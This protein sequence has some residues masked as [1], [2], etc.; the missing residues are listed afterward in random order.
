MYKIIVVL[1]SLFAV[2]HSNPNRS[3]NSFYKLLTDNPLSITKVLKNYNSRPV[4]RSS[5]S[6][7]HSGNGNKVYTTR[8]RTYHKKKPAR[9]QYYTVFP[10]SHRSAYT[11]K[12][13]I[14][15]PKSIFKPIT[16]PVTTPAPTTTPTT[17]PTPKPAPTPAK[18]PESAPRTASVLRSGIPNG[19]DYDYYG[20]LFGDYE[21][22]NALDNEE[23]GL[24]LLSE[25]LDLGLSNDV[26]EGPKVLPNNVVD[27]MRESG[28]FKV[29]LRL[30]TKLKVLETLQQLP[31]VT[32]FAPSDNVFSKMLRYSATAEDLKR[33]LIPV[34]IP[35]ESLVTG[36]AFT[37]SGE[38][39]NIVKLP[40]KIKNQIQIRYKKKNHIEEKSINVV[41]T[42]IQASNGVIHVI[43][44]FIQIID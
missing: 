18:I 7:K 30:A 32:I 35:S 41:Q 23:A 24:A 17:T 8:R 14:I 22:L 27:V 3:S 26:P 12:N 10:D 29:F 6:S 38:V 1:A 9:T 11:T 15:R 44:Q 36:P 28:Q 25:L 16:T 19:E 31:Q 43:D 39:I 42:D 40:L 4:H 33:H 34:K 37:M 21:Q 20:G 13:E 5:F 2:I